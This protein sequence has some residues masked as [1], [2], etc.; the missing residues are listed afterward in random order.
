MDDARDGSVPDRKGS[1]AQTMET[2]LLPEDLDIADAE[3]LIP[4]MEKSEGV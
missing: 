3:I 4:G 2:D 1:E